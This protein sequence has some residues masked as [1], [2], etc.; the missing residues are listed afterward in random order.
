MGNKAWSE[1]TGDRTEQRESKRRAVLMAGARL[2]NDQGYEQTS[3]EDIAEA[4]NITK[5]TIYYYV[6]SKEEILFEC[7]QLGMEFLR[8]T[9]EQCY[10]HSIPVVRRIRLLVEG[11]CAWVCTDLGA[12]APLVRE[13]SLSQE[14]RSALRQGRRQLDHLLR[15]MIGE[16]VKQG[17]LKPCDPRLM[18]S[19][20]FGALNWVPYWN[21]G[22]QQ[23]P[24]EQ[25]A[26]AYLAMITGGL[27]PVSGFEV[28]DDPVGTDRG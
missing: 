4:L 17:A 16:G 1:N 23:L 18:A 2:F 19:A 20:I 15:E 14:R 24:P 10:D 7:Q 26:D 25:I 27:V 21:R 8:E 11:Y 13:V 3:L 22:D 12:C 9:L 6:Q 28:G 5:R